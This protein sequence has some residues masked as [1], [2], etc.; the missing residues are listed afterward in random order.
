MALEYSEKPNF[1]L[2]ILNSKSTIL[3]CDDF[4]S[5]FFCFHLRAMHCN[6]A[7]GTD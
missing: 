7:R 2:F 4:F 5:F 6:K 1:E 3:Y